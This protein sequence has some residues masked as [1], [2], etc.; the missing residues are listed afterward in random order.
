MTV[1]VFVVDDH[2][3]FR[4]GVRLAL[5]DA[6]EFEMVGEASSGDE[7]LRVLRGLRPP[8]DVVLMDLRLAGGSGIEATRAIFSDP[9]LNSGEP[10]SRPPRVLIISVSEDD[11]G[12]VAALRAGA[13]GYVMKGIA[14]Q[15]LFRAISTAAEGGAV[16]SPAVASRLG[17]Y[18]SAVH[19]LPSRTAFPELTDRELQVLD[20]LARGWNNRR[21]ARDLVVSE[22]TVRN[23]IS[24]IFGKLQVN[25][26]AEAAV[27]ARDAGLGL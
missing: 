20:L 21:I 24:H 16:F 12:V 2:P 8:P 10:G 25:H 9:V 27:R 19:E 26:R 11:D 6:D 15:E 3:L 1:R 18:F 17:A 7:A 13:S 23:H 14:S 4:G 5:E 22:K